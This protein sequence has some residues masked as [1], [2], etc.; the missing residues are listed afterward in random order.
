MC[1]RI[2]HNCC[3]RCEQSTE[4]WFVLKYSLISL[5]IQ[6]D[7]VLDSLTDDG[8]ACT[9][10]TISLYQFEL[11]FVLTFLRVRSDSRSEGSAVSH[12]VSQT[13]IQ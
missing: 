13:L 1:C 8:S 5:S 2:K 12:G 9:M 6:C 4:I 10:C 3:R 11:T 7:L